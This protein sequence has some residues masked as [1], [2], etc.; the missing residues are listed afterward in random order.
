[1]KSSVVQVEVDDPLP[2]N[3]TDGIAIQV[4]PVLV[5]FQTAKAR[6]HLAAVAA[7][8]PALAA[9]FVYLGHVQ[10]EEPLR[11]ELSATYVAVRRSFLFRRSQLD[12]ANLSWIIYA[13]LS[14]FYHHSVLLASLSRFPP[15]L[16]PRQRRSSERC[17][18]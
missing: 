2:T 1:M 13:F 6:V 14:F 10:P 4:V 18:S 15:S 9:L 5:P 11:R 8:E 3:L 12:P 17:R 16:C 7:R